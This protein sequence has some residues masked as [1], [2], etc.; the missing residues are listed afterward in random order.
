MSADYRFVIRDA[1]TSAA[2]EMML[3]CAN[4][5]DALM[6]GGR[7]AGGHGLEVWDGGRQVSPDGDFAPAAI[8]AAPVETAASAPEVFEPVVV[9]GPEDSPEA[10]PEFDLEAEQGRVFNP[11]RRASWRKLRAQR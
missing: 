6:I 9:D 7:L 3:V 2:R 10:L 5:A 1:M 4:D 11:F 8:A